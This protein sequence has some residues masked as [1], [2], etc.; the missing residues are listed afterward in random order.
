MSK[1]PLNDHVANYVKRGYVVSSRTPSQVVLTKARRLGFLWWVIH[2]LLS[3]ITGGLWLIYVFYRVLR[4]KLH[5]V[6]LTVDNAGRVK[7][8]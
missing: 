4:P 3:V 6:V 2:L 5:Q 8:D 7:R 1:D